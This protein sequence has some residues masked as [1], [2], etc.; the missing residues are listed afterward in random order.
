MHQVKIFRGVENEVTAL[1]KQINAW[2]A[3][4]AVK[5][6]NIIGNLSPQSPPPADKAGSISQS[7]WPPSDVLVI[8][9]YAK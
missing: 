8:V 2:L 1:E 5:V 6:I 7:P 4:E 9:H 3:A